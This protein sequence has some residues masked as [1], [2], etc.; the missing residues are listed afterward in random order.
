MSVK[1]KPLIDA[2]SNLGAL[3]GF[4]FKSPFIA[5]F[6]AMLMCAVFGA[7]TLVMNAA[8]RGV[9]DAFPVYQTIRICALFGVG[10]G[11]LFVV[12]AS[13]VS[14]KQDP[15][16]DDAKLRRRYFFGSLL[17]A[18]VLFTLDSVSIDFIRAELEPIG[19]IM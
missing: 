4:L 9:S 7:V 13:M 10:F 1:E 19:R 2:V 14:A 5:G 17:A 18:V 3:P 11:F 12:I 8:A 15:E 6:F 16:K